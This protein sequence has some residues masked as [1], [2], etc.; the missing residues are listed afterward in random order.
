MKIT[1]RFLKNLVYQV[2]GAAIEVHKALGPGLLAG[3]NL[4]F[5][6]QAFHPHFDLSQNEKDRPAFGKKKE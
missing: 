2:N 1:R 4:T 6:R 5:H 3:S